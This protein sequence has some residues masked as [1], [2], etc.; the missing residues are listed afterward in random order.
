[1]MPAEGAV[2]VVNGSNVSNGS[3]FIVQQVDRVPFVGKFA[4]PVLQSRFVKPFTERAD[5]YVQG[6]VIRATPYV[7]GAVQRAT[8]YVEGVV[9]RTSPY[10]E[11]VVTRATPYVQAAT[12]I[13]QG[14]IE[15]VRSAPG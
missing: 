12:P 1:M 3:T 4:T 7:E 14:S 10:V 9:T 8:P 11:G 15:T 13:V 6:G 2:Q 5:P